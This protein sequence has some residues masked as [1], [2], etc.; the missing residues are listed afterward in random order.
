MR[1]EFKRQD[2]FDF[3]HFIGT[4]AFSKG[5]EL[6]FLKCP[7][8]GNASRDKNTFAINLQTGAFNCKRASCGVT[9]NM[10][11]LH[12]DFDFKLEGLDEE[13]YKPKMKKPI[14]HKPIDSE[15]EAIKYLASRGISEEVAKRYQITVQSKNPNILVFPFIRNEN[16]IECIK[17][18]NTK[19]VKGQGN[20]E[21]FQPNGNMILFGM[22]QCNLENKTLVITEGQIDSLSVAESGIENAVSVPNG[23]MGFTWIPNCWAWVNQFDTIIVF[24]DHEKGHITLLEEISKRFKKHI[25][26]VRES[27]Y[28][29]CKDANEILV[30]YGKGQ[31]RK[32]VED[33]VDVPVKHT[34]DLADVEE[35]DIF[36]IEK[37]PTGFEK[38]DR[39]L[40]GGLPFG[41]IT[42]IAGKP[43]KGKSSVASMILLSAM[44]NGHRCF[45]YS[46]ELP[47]GMFKSWMNYQ[48][49][50]RN[51]VFKY[52][53]RYGDE[54][55]NIS[56]TNKH[57][58]SEWY[59]GKLK[60]Y[61][62]TDLPDDEDEQISLVK[63]IEEN[64]QINGTDVI[65]V[66]NLMTA[67][68]LEATAETDKYERQSK[69]VKKLVRL[70]Q[71]Y[72]CCV[73]LVAHKRKNNFSADENDEI[74][75]SGDIA[76]LGMITLAYDP[77]AEL[78]ESQRRLKLVKNRLFGRLNTEGWVMNYDEPSKRIYIDGERVDYEFGWNKTDANGFVA[79][80]DDEDIPY[81]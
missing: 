50:G 3:A 24:G 29:D 46:G 1:Y 72:N 44:Q 75:G 45:V 36:D 48:A 17:Y 64:I 59:R 76:N 70:S 51:H 12:K 39:M 52:Q 49:A 73:I 22:Y 63:L 74:S 4:R 8:C 38:L 6:V 42:L 61:R 15:P 27:D 66:D 56:D 23:A 25:K 60:L 20:K 16:E 19:Y 55:Y 13:Y 21:W 31:V 18:R 2:A 43:G 57:L 54:G 7:Y 5:D 68:D 53:T 71:T 80:A 37:L 62:P 33:A 67:L 9:G 77:D 10:L 35:L 14:K 47:N 79:V 28:K 58:I 41:G 78:D 34:V 69:F 40:Y 11:T 32:C 81:D 30:K 26:H 65:L